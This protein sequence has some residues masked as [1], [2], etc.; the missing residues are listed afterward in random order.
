[1]TRTALS[2]RLKI[3][4]W[5]APAFGFP[6]TFRYKT[7]LVSKGGGSCLPRQLRRR[8]VR[9]TGS[10]IAPQNEECRSKEDCLALRRKSK[11]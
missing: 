10:T 6:H 8:C 1:M 2:A 5:I 3:F 7:E 11:P 4:V 9:N